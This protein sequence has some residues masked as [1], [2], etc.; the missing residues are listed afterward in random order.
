MIDA[1]A[2]AKA[3][4]ELLGLSSAAVAVAFSPEPPPGLPRVATPAPSGCTYWRRAADGEAFTTI[5][6]DHFG[7]AVGAYTHGAELGQPQQAE[8]EGLIGTMVGLEYLSKDEVARIP[9]RK[10]KLGAVSYAPLASAPFAPDVVLVRASPRAAMVLEEAAHAAGARDAGAAGLR[11]ACATIPQVLASR[12][13]THSL[14]CVGNRV[15]TGL[16]DGEVW[17]A[18]PGGVLEGVLERLAVVARANRELEAFH[19]ARLTPASG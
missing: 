14:A 5:A 15:Y 12:R 16:P 17:V 2:A 13:T 6:E 10:D 9:T 4:T 1:P 18:L 8:L 11:P 3:L 7:C 19:R